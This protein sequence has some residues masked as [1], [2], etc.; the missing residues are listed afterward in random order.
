MENLNQIKKVALNMTEFASAMGIG[1]NKAFELTRQPGF[2]TVM[3]GR[4]IIIPV[5]ALKAWLDKQA[6]NDSDI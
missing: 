4:R 1:R 2:P 6:A 5:E 3:L